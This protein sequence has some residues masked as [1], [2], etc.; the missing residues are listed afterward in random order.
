MCCVWLGLRLVRS[1]LERNVCGGVCVGDWLGWVREGRVGA[2]VCVWGSVFEL[3]YAG[4]AVAWAWL[5]C[6]C[7]MLWTGCDIA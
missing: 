4:S 7:G 1:K 5:R 2:R 6:E 3:K